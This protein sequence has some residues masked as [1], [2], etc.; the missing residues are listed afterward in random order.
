MYVTF[1]FWGDS[2]IDSFL[3][4]SLPSILAA[5]NLPYLS[6][7]IETVL[8]IYT[9]EAGYSRI[10]ANDTFSRLNS[11]PNVKVEYIDANITL[12]ERLDRSSQALQK[13]AGLLNKSVNVAVKISE[14][15][16]ATIDGNDHNYNNLILTCC[17]FD[18]LRI[19]SSE[20]CPCIFLGPDGVYSRSTLRY[21][22]E[23]LSL[24]K[25]AFLSSHLRANEIPGREVCDSLA[26]HDDNVKIIDMHGRRLVRLGLD[27]MHRVSQSMFWPEIYTTYDNKKHIFSNNATQLYC[28]VDNDTVLQRNFTL[29]PLMLY[30]VEPVVRHGFLSIDM[31]LIRHAVKDYNSVFVCS[32]SDLQMTIDLTPESYQ[33]FDKH[34]SDGEPNY[35]EIARWFW[36]H[37]DGFH[38]RFMRTPVVLHS[39][40][41]VNQ[42]K[43][44]EMISTTTSV[45]DKIT[46]TVNEMHSANL[47]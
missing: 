32:D 15:E 45:I 6:Q 38:E 18:A 10:N 20:N 1:A 30:P 33:G 11:L 26:R 44:K 22:W 24:G 37:N 8:L 14:L 7:R 4:Y 5:E 41:A 19:A 29:H 3:N 9:D 40:E 12:K 2:Y 31:S 27:H 36:I 13:Q 39:E 42:H 17:N 28:Q 21:V 34:L 25:R 16:S 47:L 35:S 46:S 23:A 43:L